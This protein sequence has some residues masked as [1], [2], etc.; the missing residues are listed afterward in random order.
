ME[1]LGGIYDVRGCPNSIRRSGTRAA[2]RGAAMNAMHARGGYQNNEL[3]P[4]VFERINRARMHLKCSRIRASRM[5]AHR[6]A[7]SPAPLLN[8]D[9]SPSRICAPSSETGP[10]RE[11]RTDNEQAPGL[12]VQLSRLRLKHQCLFSEI[13]ASYVQHPMR[14]FLHVIEFFIWK[15]YTNKCDGI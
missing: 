14:S 12:P 13:K 3:T 1:E 4:D 5:H 9:R 7:S 11:F 15:G 8:R 10:P 6:T 2:Q